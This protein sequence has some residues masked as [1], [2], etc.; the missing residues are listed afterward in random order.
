[1]RCVEGVARPRSCVTSS[2]TAAVSRVDLHLPICAPAA[3]VARTARAYGRHQA[4]R[5]NGSVPSCSGTSASAERQ[6]FR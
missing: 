2:P 1:V 4:C 6:L 3:V 5:M